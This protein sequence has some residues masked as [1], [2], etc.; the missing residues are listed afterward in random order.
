MTGDGNINISTCL[1]HFLKIVDI[2]STKL[3]NK[4][5]AFLD[6]GIYAARSETRE[7]INGGVKRA[8]DEERT[9]YKRLVLALLREGLC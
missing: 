4:V 9:C 6:D 3:V 2:L 5:H 8:H 1:N 7:G